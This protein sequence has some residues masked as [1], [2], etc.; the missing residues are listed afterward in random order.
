MPYLCDL[1]RL[2]S[3]ADPMSLRSQ[4]CRQYNEVGAVLITHQTI[5]ARRETLETTQISRSSGTIQD[6][7]QRLSR[8]GNN[9]RRAPRLALAGWLTCSLSFVAIGVRM[10]AARHYSHFTHMLRHSTIAVQQL[11]AAAL[12]SP[13]LLIR[14]VLECRR[15]AASHTCTTR[16]V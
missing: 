9:A 2:I 11:Y 16:M 3:H 5:V 4:S 10:R 8:I 6:T 13:N 1:L 12:Y 15:K 7:H 14:V